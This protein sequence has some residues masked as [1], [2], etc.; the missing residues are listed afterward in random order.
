MFNLFGGGQKIEIKIPEPPQCEDWDQLFQLNK[1]KEVIGIYLSAHPLDEYKVEIETY[2]NTSLGDFQEMQSLKGKEIKVAGMITAVEHK[3]TKTGSPWGSIT[4]E[5]FTDSYRI[6]FFSKD[7]IEFKKYFTV[8]YALLLRGK[9]QAR[10]NDEKELEFKPTVIDLLPEIRSKMIQSL[11]IKVPV[12]LLTE[13]LITDFEQLA[14]HN[15]GN[16]LLK[17]VIYDPQTKVWVQ[18]A[19]RSYKIQV[20]SNVLEYLD[21]RSEIEYKIF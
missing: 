9:V 6:S 20:N 14:N 2:C 18:M 1:E 7:Y 19:S 10:F 5:D 12:N 11:A 4:I 16:A 21:A 13:D 15:K 17:F 8:G 3:T